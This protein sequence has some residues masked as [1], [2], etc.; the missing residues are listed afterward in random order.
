VET[1]N[2]LINVH[3]RAGQWRWALQIFDDML[4][5]SVSS[6]L[7]KVL[8]S[9]LWCYCRL[10]VVQDNTSCGMKGVFALDRTRLRKYFILFTTFLQWYKVM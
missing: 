2:A 4:R 1:Y 10:R 3:G 5:A 6:L 8:C 9:V 7:S